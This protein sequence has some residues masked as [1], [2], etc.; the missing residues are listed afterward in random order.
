[1]CFAFTNR[2]G[3]A[4]FR[5]ILTTLG[6]LILII[7]NQNCIAT[8]NRLS[9]SSK[10]TVKQDPAL[11]SGVN[12]GNGT[13]YGG[14]LR[15][16]TYVRP[17][18]EQI[19]GSEIKN[20]GE[21]VVTEESVTGKIINSESCISVD[22]NLDIR[23]LEFAE[24]SEG[25]IGYFE[26]IYSDT[27]IKS[28]KSENTQAVENDGIEEVWCRK[29]GSAANVGFDIVI[30]ADY[31]KGEFTSI[32]ASASMGSDGQ[33]TEQRYQPL[34]VDRR[35]DDMDRVRYRATNFE[36]EIR[37]RS[38]N[39][40]SGLMEGDLT[41]ALNGINTDMRISCRLGGELDVMIPKK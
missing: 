39:K 24:Y 14:K 27:K 20:L 4:M 8:G 33:I 5:I 28:G 3:G 23:D 12:G 25:R 2:N 10:S 34:L 1:M 7:F 11:S 26:G 6:C 22:V 35:F 41:Y 18:T 29:E 19:C 16:G 15:P 40:G 32:A 31:K 17:L 13:P 37:Q 9:T 38:F 21:I 30:K 36:L